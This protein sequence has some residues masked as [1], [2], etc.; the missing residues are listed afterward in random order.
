MLTGSGYEQ[1]SFFEAGRR[2]RRMS[3]LISSRCRAGFDFP[4]M[5]SEPVADGRLADLAT[6]TALE[7]YREPP[8]TDAISTFVS[9]DNRLLR[10]CLSG[11]SYEYK[12]REIIANVIG[13]HLFST[14]Q[15]GAQRSL[16][17]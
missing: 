1:Q 2:G 15:H 11:V 9:D 16:Q 10:I 6:S 7:T 13:C 3:A 5:V 12:A 4:G 8:L 17:G 14:W